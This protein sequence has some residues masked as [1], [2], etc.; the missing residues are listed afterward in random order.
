MGVKQMSDHL[1]NK[2]TEENGKPSKKT[3]KKLL[4]CMGKYEFSYL[5]SIVMATAG[6]ALFDVVTSYMLKNLMELAQRKSTDGLFQMIAVNFVLGVACLF[7]WRFSIVKYNIEAKRGIATLEKKVFSKA[8]LL[9]MEYYESHHTGDFMSKLIYDTGKAGDVFGSRLRRL[10]APIL[11]VLVF[12]V[13]M[14]LLSW[15]VTGALFL[16]SLI[17][18]VI[19]AAFVKPMK[20]LGTELSKK[21]G[22]MAENLTN[23]LSGIELCKIFGI[24]NIMADKY[25][26]SNGEF[27]QTQKKKNVMSACLEGLNEG[28]GLISVLAFL[29]VGVWFVSIGEVS[30]GNL[31]A[32]YAMYG[33]FSWHFLQI[34]HY[35]P[36]LT[37]CLANAE[38]VFTFLEQDIEPATYE[39]PAAKGEGYIV[40]ENLCFAYE[41]DRKVLDNF[42]LTL[43]KGKTVAITGKSGRG[44]STLA[45]ILLGFYSPQSG[46]ISID[47]KGFGSMTLEEIRN[48]IAYVPQEPYLYDVSIAENISYG[49]PGATIEEITAAAKAANAHDFIEKLDNGYDTMAGER[50]SRLSG[51]EKQ[52]IAIARA[53]LKNAP[54]LLLDEATSALDNESEQ[55]VSDAIDHLSKGRTTIMIAHRPATIARADRVVAM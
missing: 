29:A 7:L 4:R 41:E 32:I 34:G 1:E 44:K 31:T 54:I 20:R 5:L 50:G 15:K 2:A 16:I 27:L 40:M 12:S 21:N 18:L 51:G 17:T 49:R 8:M 26:E 24:G 55:L 46:A 36:E 47:G 22:C 3:L 38:R 10:I 6:M 23:I 43:E 28:L 11:S 37:N 53:V 30:L 52:R 19:N 9:P 39:I 13:P 35:M 14:F 42:S 45:K 25:K 48:Q 33:P